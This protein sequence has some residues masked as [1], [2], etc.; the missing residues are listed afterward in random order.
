LAGV[1]VALPLSDCILLVHPEGGS[2]DCPFAGSASICGA[3]VK[4]HCQA[5]V[6]ACCVDA[7]CPALADLEACGQTHGSECTK[8]QSA[9]SATG[10]DGD[11]GR[12]V[13]SKCL[14][15]CQPF[16]GTSETSCHVPSF[17]GGEACTC[18]LSSTPNDFVCGQASF[19]NTR[20]CAPA[21]WPS[22]GTQCS[23]QILGCSPSSDGCDCNLVDYATGEQSCTAKHCCV[24]EDTCACRSTA[25]YPF[26]IAVARCEASVIRCQSGQVEVKDCSIFKGP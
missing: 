21:G 8:L 1:G 17:G 5:A 20:C 24:F 23:C 7:G 14:G 13:A 22:T 11:L 9:K 25:C 12:C 15:E 19:A 3:C 4:S 10:P 26:E 6:N 16:S 18:Q 2:L